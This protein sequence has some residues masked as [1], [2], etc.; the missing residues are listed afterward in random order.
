MAGALSA[1][2]EFGVGPALTSRIS[3]L[4]YELQ[5]LG[6]S[7]LGQALQRGS[8]TGSVLSA[9]MLVKQV[10]RQIDVTIHALGILLAL[11]GL[12]EDGEVVEALSLGAGNT[13]R[14]YD[15]ETDRR[16]AEFKFIAWQGGPESIRQNGLFADVFR[17]AESDTTKRRQMFVIGLQQPIKFLNGGRSLTSV[18][19]KNSKV[20]ADFFGRYGDQFAKVRDYWLTVKDRVELVDVTLLV[21]VL[22]GLP[23]DSDET[24]EA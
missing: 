18:L 20:S 10:S 8:A 15:L 14:M 7:S 3:Q 21:P 9:A 17:L 6:R 22:V 13:G 5:G 2:S 19:S 16:V 12:L 11:P 23:P 24:S 1:L 4:E